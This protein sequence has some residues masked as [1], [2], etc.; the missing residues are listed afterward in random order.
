MFIK[1][2]RGPKC[3]RRF[4]E[5]LTDAKDLGVKNI[6]VLERGFNGWEASGRPVCRCNDISCKGEWKSNALWGWLQESKFCYIPDD[7]RSVLI[8]LF[9]NRIWI[10][11]QYSTVCSSSCH[12]FLIERRNIWVLHIHKIMN[13]RKSGC[14]WVLML[15]VGIYWLYV[16]SLVC[17]DQP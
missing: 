10:Y 7:G 15:N 2:V 5:Y 14:Y 11:I 8:F 12:Y 1:Q 17:I 16:C 9:D 4:A 6:M 13:T 3:A